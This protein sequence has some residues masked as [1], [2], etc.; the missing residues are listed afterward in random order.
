MDIN[1]F[2]SINDVYGHLEG[3]NALR[4]VGCILKKTCGRFGVFLSRYGGDE[5]A[6]LMAP[7]QEYSPEYLIDLLNEEIKLGNKQHP[8]SDQIAIS[9]GISEYDGSSVTP[10]E[11][12]I[13][14]ADAEMYRDKKR[15]HLN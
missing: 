10:L 15:Q 5:F 11:S 8:D 7:N 2:K 14:N 13:K 9:Y 12:F 6:I 3:D 1:N 4:T